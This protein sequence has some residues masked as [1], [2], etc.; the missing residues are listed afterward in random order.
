MIISKICNRLYNIIESIRYYYSKRKIYKYPGVN[1]RGTDLKGCNTLFKDVCCINCEVGKY[2]YIQQKSFLL[3]THIGKFCSIAD[4]VRTGFGNHPTQLMSTWPGFYYDTTSELKYTF[5]TGKPQIDIFKK[6]GP[7]GGNFVVYIGNDVWIGSHVLIMDG[8]TIGDG[9]VIA[10]GAVV[11]KDVEPYAIYG[12]VP[13]RLIKYRFSQERIQAFLDFKWWEKN[14]EWIRNN[15]EKFAKPD[16]LL[17][18]IK[19]SI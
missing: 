18:V 15:I 17:Y 7:V 8:V 13:A 5:Y 11:T 1:V 14:D 19:E 2:S 4:H 3:N 12:G 9:A 16:E 6:T 10:A